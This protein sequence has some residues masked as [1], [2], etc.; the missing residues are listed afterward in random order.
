[1]QSVVIRNVGLQRGLGWKTE[2]PTDVYITNGRIQRIA[3]GNSLPAYQNVNTIDGTNK[4]LMPGLIFAHTHIA[5]DNVCGARDVLF[6][7]PLIRL[8]YIAAKVAKRATQLG[9]T[10]MIGAGSISGLDVY[11]KE[12]ISSGLFDGP[13]IIPCSR[14]IMA[15]G[16]L[17][18]RSKEKV[19]HIPADYMPVLTEIDEID[20]AVNREIDDGAVI[21]KTF[22]TGDDQFPNANSNEEL[23][24]FEELLR[25]VQI[26]RQRNVLIRCHARGLSGIK[27]A[28]KAGVDIIDHATYADQESLDNILANNISIVPSYYQL[29]QYL[30]NGHKYGKHP[31]ESNFSLEIENTTKFL[32]VA[33]KMGIN[34]A[35][36][37][38]FGFAWTPHGTYHEELLSYQNQLNIPA[39]II[40]KWATLNGAKMINAE[41]RIGSLEEGKQA[42]MILL[43]ADPAK[44]IGVLSTHIEQVFI[45]G[46]AVNMKN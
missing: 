4:I 23:F 42:D 27:N 13:Q 46:N 39:E 16:P 20:A 30:E 28:I 18:K 45:S 12:A 7:H 11:L 35:V 19:A 33:E 21:L 3:S 25:M 9:Y 1:M 24:V 22:A 31:E 8:A 34:I 32:P 43:S 15:A 14:D 5:Y 6:K 37:D 17:G 38:D 40:I 41:A 10:T 2:P 29:K 36:G 44:D 26:A